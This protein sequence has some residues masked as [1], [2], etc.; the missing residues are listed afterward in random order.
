MPSGFISELSAF[1]ANIYFKPNQRIHNQLAT[2]V[3]WAGALEQQLIRCEPMWRQPQRGVMFIA[4]LMKA[5]LS[6]DRSDICCLDVAPLGPK[7]PPQPQ[8][9]LAPVMIN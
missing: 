8:N 3:S 6:S 1:P 5:P 2:S 4:L 7:K 9:P